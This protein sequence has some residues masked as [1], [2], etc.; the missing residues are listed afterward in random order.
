[1]LYNPLL[2]NK[3]EYKSNVLGDNVFNLLDKTFIIPYTFK[4]NVIE[5]TSDFIG[6]MDLISKKMYGDARYADILCKLNGISNPFELNDGDLI[7]IPDITELS[8]FYYT[9]TDEEKE[10]DSVNSNG[11]SSK[12]V[13]KSKAEKRA[14]NEAVKGDKRYHVDPNRRVIVY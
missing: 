5:C 8:N 12:P 7:V 14:P 3:T 13:A 9:E 1:M 10:E 4:Y 2:E 11:G 6:R